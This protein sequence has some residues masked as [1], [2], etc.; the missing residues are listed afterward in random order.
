MRVYQ[1]AIQPSAGNLTPNL[2]TGG[3]LGVAPDAPKSGLQREGTEEVDRVGRLQREHQPPGEGVPAGREQVE[4][5]LAH[6]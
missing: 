2:S 1:R 6:R 5:L 3:T 4:K